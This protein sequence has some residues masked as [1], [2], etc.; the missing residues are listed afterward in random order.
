MSR[1]S[2]KKMV[3]QLDINFVKQNR[4]SE[5]K[6]ASDEGKKLRGTQDFQRFFFYYRPS[7]Y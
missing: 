4:R 5:I 2:T 1:R 3:L 6:F 7:L